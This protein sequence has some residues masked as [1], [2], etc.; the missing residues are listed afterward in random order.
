MPSS[1]NLEPVRV[2]AV[3]L[4][5]KTYPE[6]FKKYGEWASIGGIIWEYVKNP[7]TD[8]SLYTKNFALP[9]FPNI[10][11]IPVENEI[12]LL[13]VSSDSGVLNDVTSYQYYYLPPT[14][15]WASSHHNATPD[16]IYSNPG[17]NTLPS[18]Q[19][20]D[21]PLVGGT[22]V[23]RV[24]DEGTEIFKPGDPFVENSYIRTLA[25]YPGDV[26][27]EGRYGNSLRFS[28]TSKFGLKNNWSNYQAFNAP[29]TI[30]RN[31]QKIDFKQDPWVN[32]SEDINTDFSSIYLTSNQQIQ[33][34]PSSFSTAGYKPNQYTPKSISSYTDPQVILS[35]NRLVFNSR[36]DSIILSAA[37]GI[38]LSTNDSINVDTGL[39]TI[40]SQEINLGASDAKERAIKGDTFIKEMSS[41]LIALKQV[42]VALSTAANAGGPVQSLIDVSAT[43]G[44]AINNLQTALGTKG[45]PNGD[46][47]NSKVLSDIVKLQ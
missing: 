31:G 32:I 6:L 44:S 39:I 7:T 45:S 23:R 37:K 22:L 4:D 13:V 34:I 46:I 47:T 26:L 38:L 11:H 41:F 25:P 16:Q 35:S 8:K 10:K 24:N 29:I 5:D 19:K 27:V 12:V 14:N 28:S 3:I 43:F 9:L 36:S 33:L 18:S 17:V 15:V 1:L 21:Y 20:Q 2:L 42:Q 30:L 40:R